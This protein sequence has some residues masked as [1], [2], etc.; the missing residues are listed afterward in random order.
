VIYEY[1][2][3]Y[4]RICI[5]VYI[6]TLSYM[7]ICVYL[8]IS[9]S[10][11]NRQRLYSTGTS[12]WYMNIYIHRIYTYILRVFSYGMQINAYICMY[13]CIYTY[14]FYVRMN[15]SAY[16]SRVWQCVCVCSWGCRGLCHT[17]FGACVGFYVYNCHVYILSWV[18]TN[19]QYE[20]VHINICMFVWIFLRRSLQKTPLYICVYKRVYVYM[21]LFEE[22]LTQDT[23]SYMCIYTYMYIH[24]Y[25]YVYLYIYIHIC[26]YLYICINIY[27]CIYMYKYV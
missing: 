2:H 15:T 20:C 8:P 27:I 14:R 26:I 17:V 11:G 12:I 1:V 10:F 7:C 16:L 9:R 6:H 13:V 5:L 4:V 3:T 18:Y 23:N 25:I 22:G 24:I 19:H 21:H